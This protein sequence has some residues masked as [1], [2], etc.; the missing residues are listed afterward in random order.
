MPG[1][2]SN[3]LVLD[4]ETSPILAYVWTLRDPII[5]PSQ[6]KKDWTILCWSAKWYGSHKLP[7][8]YES[9]TGSDREILKPLWELLNEADIVVTQNGKH[10]DSKKINARFMAHGMKPPKPYKHHDTYLIAK[11]AAGFTSNRLEYL[12]DK[13]CKKY[14]KTSHGKFSGNSLWI[15]CLKGNPAAWR[16]LKIYNINDV[17]ATEELYTEIRPWAPESAAKVYDVTDASLECGTCG[18]EGQMRIGKPRKAKSYWYEQY[19]CPSC[20]SWQP[21]VKIDRPR[22]AND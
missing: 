13:L 10:F 8:Y 7:S 1:A 19:S 3:V 12:T 4:I 21:G 9:R 22:K 5:T 11:H 20:G 17:L 2:K 16:E 6:I 14:K 15:E 18:Y